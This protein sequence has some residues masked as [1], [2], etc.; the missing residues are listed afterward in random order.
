MGYLDQYMHIYL[1]I[2]QPLVCK[3]VMSVCR[4]SFLPVEDLL[5]NIK[6]GSCIL[7]SLLGK[8]RVTKWINS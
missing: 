1:N 8:R 7:E 6:R 3:M 5:A 4:A 2:V